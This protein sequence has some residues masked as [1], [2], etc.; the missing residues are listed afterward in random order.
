MIYLNKRP[1]K[2]VFGRHIGVCNRGTAA[3]HVVSA[4]ATLSR[5]PGKCGDIGDGPHVPAEPTRNS[6]L[7]TANG[8][9]QPQPTYTATSASATAAAAAI[10]ATL[11]PQDACTTAGATHCD[12][13][14][15]SGR[16]LDLCAV[17]GG[18]CLPPACV[19]QE[20]AESVPGLARI[21]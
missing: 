15:F 19:P 14:N 7:T 18:R 2:D 16:Q 1:L 4:R 13:T 10:V 11:G 9:S 8:A 20:C 6:L 3:A 21:R 12:G 17:C 5:S